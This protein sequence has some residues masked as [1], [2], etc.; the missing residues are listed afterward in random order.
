MTTITV[1]KLDPSGKETWRYSGDLIMRSEDRLVIEAFFDRDDM[2]FN[3]MW[4]RKGDR[5]IETYFTNRWYN[6]FEIYEN[7]AQ[8][9]KGWYCNVATPVEIDGNIISYKDLALDLL[10]F[11]NGRQLVL[12]EDEFEV[13]DLSPKMA[14]K[15]KLALGEL[16]ALFGSWP[17]SGFVE[18]L[19]S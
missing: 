17:K 5:F 6:I 9:P 12:D 13:L 18:Q 14:S 10:V 11:P 16:Q 4:L 2:L 8:S 3:G 7:G 1:I 15:A 19:G